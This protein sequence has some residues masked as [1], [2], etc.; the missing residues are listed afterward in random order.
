MSDL[1]MDIVLAAEKGDLEKVKN[2][3]KD[4]ASPD[5]MGP[6]S[7]ALHCAAFNGHKEIVKLLLKNGARTD[8]KDNQ[9]FYPLHLAASK[10][11]TAIC[12]MLIKAGADL[13]AKTS[14]GGTALHVA[15]V[16]NFGKVVT[17]LV[18]AGAN[19]EA[20]DQ[21][22]ESP[23]FSA[24]WMGRNKI[25]KSLIKAGSDI[26]ALNV[27]GDNALITALRALYDARIKSWKSI[28]S[29]NGRD[30]KYEVIKGC[31]RYDSSYNPDDKTKLGN[32]MTL[33]DQRYCA[34]QSWGPTEHLKYLDAFDTV[35]TLLKSGADIHVVGRDNQNALAVA[36]SCGEAKLMKDL[37]KAGASFDNVTTKGATPLHSVSSS[38]RLDGL[39]MFF[40]LAE[41]YDIHAGD[42]WGWTPLHYLAD[43]G[44]HLKMAELLLSKGADKNSKSTKDRGEGTPA[45]CTPSEVAY[46]WKDKE[47]G[48]A[49]KS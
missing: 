18:K 49:L 21:Y 34:S 32:V 39:E 31:F 36:C 4:G 41:N 35:K 8:I 10:G 12:T 30:V 17:A 46:H 26:H 14:K 28:G 23:M 19:L 29:N 33:K 48:D 22:D 1:T 9:S 27:D 47:M 5:A 37:F 3:L 6:N 38:G 16:S 24:V 20:K 11:E 45:G 42:N 13:E 43:A 2:A 25:I 15:A 40:N 7:G 44:G